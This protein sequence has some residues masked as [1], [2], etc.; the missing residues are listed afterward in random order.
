MIVL[1]ALLGL[2]AV[3]FAVG[4]VGPTS[5]A[6]TQMIES[7]KWLGANGLYAIVML[8]PVFVAFIPLLI[9]K[10]KGFK[11]WAFASVYGLLIAFIFHQLGLFTLIVEL[12]QESLFY[13]SWMAGWAGLKSVGLGIFHFLCGMAAR[14]CDVLIFTTERVKRLTERARRWFK[15]HAK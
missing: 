3:L 14:A 6:M 11:A 2:A 4:M 9:L 5:E 12:M 7:M 15:R 10:D 8:S 1:Y 13:S